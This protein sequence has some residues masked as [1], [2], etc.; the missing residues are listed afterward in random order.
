[1]KSQTQKNMKRNN[2]GCENFAAVNINWFSQRCYKSIFYPEWFDN[3]MRWEVV[4][5]VVLRRDPAVWMTMINQI[6]FFFWSNEFKSVLISSKWKSKIFKYPQK[7]NVEREKTRCSASQIV[8]ER[9]AQK[10][11][12]SFII[13]KKLHQ[14]Y[15]VGDQKGPNSAVS[16]GS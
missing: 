3:L 9:G 12:W 2:S 5:L 15:Q 11:P 4:V 16:W 7:S 10:W 1:M 14:K 6:M 8:S 13:W